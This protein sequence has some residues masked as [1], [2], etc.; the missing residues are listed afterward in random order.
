MSIKRH[1]YNN[2]SG[3]EVSGIK[4]VTTESGDPD[5]FICQTCLVDTT[6]NV[7]AEVIQ[8]GMIDDKHTIAIECE[9]CKTH[10]V[11]EYRLEHWAYGYIP[12][13]SA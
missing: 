8:F 7:I 3:I 9:K 1:Y 6:K 2:V 12:L 13:V 11:V 4:L 5:D 10:Y